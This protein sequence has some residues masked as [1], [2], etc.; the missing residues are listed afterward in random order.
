ML[1]SPANRTIHYTHAVFVRMWPVLP[2]LLARARVDSQ[3]MQLACQLTVSVLA[4]WLAL[5]SLLLRHY[6]PVGLTFLGSRVI[7]SQSRV[8]GERSERDESRSDE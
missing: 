2:P 5:A 4:C 3:E 1:P 6:R 7:N 8:V